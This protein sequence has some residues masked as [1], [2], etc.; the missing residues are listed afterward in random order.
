V[1]RSRSAT[2][3]RSGVLVVGQRDR[4]AA[5]GG[6]DA[7]RGFAVA[8]EVGVERDRGPVG[9]PRQDRDPDRHGGHR[10]QR[11]GRVLCVGVDDEQL[12]VVDVRL[13]LDEREP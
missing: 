11:E 2:I 5:A 1:S 6:H 8:V 7:E 9:G 12:V 10:R 13:V 4:R 3:R